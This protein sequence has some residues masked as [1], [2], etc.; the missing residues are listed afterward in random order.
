M[1]L[2]VLCISIA[3]AGLY[4]SLSWLSLTWMGG[5]VTTVEADS[6]PVS[7]SIQS[8]LIGQQLT[9]TRQ[10]SAS[11]YLSRV[12]SLSFQSLSPEETIS[13]TESQGSSI[14]YPYNSYDSGAFFLPPYP[15]ESER[16]GFGKTLSQ[17]DTSVLNAGWY[18]NWGANH[19]PNHVGGAEYVRTIRFSIQDTGGVVCGWAPAPATTRSQ[20]TTSLTG[21]ALINNIQKNPGALWTIGNEPDVLFQRAAIQAEL[22]ADLY[23]DLYTIIKEADPTAKV[24]IGGIVQPSPLRLAYLDRLFDYYESTYGQPLPMDVWNTHLYILNETACNWGVLTPPFI[25]GPGWE[26]AFHP[27]EVLDR[28]RMEANLRTLRAWMYYRGYG[29]IP[30][31]ITEYGVLPSPEVGWPNAWGADFL[32]DMN[33]IFLTATDPIY[34]YA[35]DGNRLVQAWAWFSTYWAPFGGDLFDANGQLTNIGQ[36]FINETS[37]LYTPYIDLQPIPP[38]SVNTATNFLALTGYVQNRGN[39]DAANATLELALVDGTSGLTATTTNLNLALLP[40][41]YEEPP[42]YIDHTWHITFSTPPTYTVPY[43]LSIGVATADANPANDRLAIPIHWWP[44]AD[45]AVS[46]LIFSPDPV[47]VANQAVPVVVTATVANVGLLPTP[48]T[49]FSMG[50]Q[51][52]DGQT[53]QFLTNALVPALQPAQS[54]LFTATL[55]ISQPGSFTLFAFLPDPLGPPEITN[56]NRLDV[57]LSPLSPAIFLPIIAK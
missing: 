54:Q 43:T 7:E 12:K 1:S 28:A 53:A 2:K 41:R 18:L 29:D 45:L 34:G 31:I 32:K 42:T 23:H 49:P 39:V 40:A 13:R 52:P 38:T 35:P 15:S 44:L 6:G 47:L 16:M 30:L 48:Q 10:V 4:L 50:I 20:V 11:G 37:E 51:P 33:D 3:L 19:N 25:E 57:S 8:N 27:S 21:T 46:S 9:R 5:Q 14:A 55:L 17:V 24:A 56:N 36:T 22:Y 26:V